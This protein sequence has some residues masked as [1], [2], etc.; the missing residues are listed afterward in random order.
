M[1]CISHQY[2]RRGEE[3]NMG[4]NNKL[5]AALDELSS[6]RDETSDHPALTLAHV[7]SNRGDGDIKV[8]DVVDGLKR[9]HAASRSERAVVRPAERSGESEG[10]FRRQR[11]LVI[12]SLSDGDYGLDVHIVDSI[13]KL[14]PI[15]TVPNTPDYVEGVTNLRGDV[16]PVVDLR[17]LLGRSLQETGKDS[18]IVVVELPETKIGLLVDAVVEVLRIDQQMIR[19]PS[20]LV[21]TIDAAFIDGVVNMGALEAGMS[22]DRLI[23]LLNL[24]NTLS[25]EQ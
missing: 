19:P 17:R 12:F 1:H 24:E 16:L 9:E 3:R 6:Q 7:E 2:V 10:E 13:I 18:R 15:T 20:P 4:Q 8:E 14:Q 22:G 25:I 11:Q 21:S 23:V 5:E